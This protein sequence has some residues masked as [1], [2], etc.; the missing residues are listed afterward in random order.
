MTDEAVLFTGE[1]IDL[2]YYGVTG[3]SGP[4][5]TAVA[6]AQAKGVAGASLRRSRTPLTSEE[7][8]HVS[9]VFYDPGSGELPFFGIRP[10]FVARHSELDTLYRRMLRASDKLRVAIGAMEEEGLEE[11][12]SD[13]LATAQRLVFGAQSSDAYWRG[14]HPGFTDPRERDAVLERLCAAEAMIDTLIQGEQDWIG[15]EEEDR[16]GDL[17]EEV[18]AANRYLAAWL[19]PARAGA[20][21][22]LDDRQKRCSLL[23]AGVRRTEPF[24]ADMAQAELAGEAADLQGPPKRGVD[25]RRLAL[26]LPAVADDIERMGVREWLLDA[27]VT[28][29]EL[30]SGTV[31]RSA[32]ELPAT[33]VLENRIDE[34]GDCSYTLRVRSRLRL[35]GIRPRVATVYKATVLAIDAPK[36]SMAFDVELEGDGDALLALEVPLRLGTTTPRLHVDGESIETNRTVYPEVS[37]LRVDGDGRPVLLRMNPPL[38]VWVLPVRTTLRDLDGYRAVDQGLVAV[39]VLPVENRASMRVVLQ[40]GDGS[41]L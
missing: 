13:V 23:D 25:L 16:D 34:T 40:V 22:T 4:A 19:V 29:D 27:D 37:E 32:Q 11:A 30:F 5:A 2:S 1:L 20:I 38:D 35:D 39:P 18:F 28:P 36:V 6:E 24:I 31:D 33:E 21:R 26:D 41:P 10:G 12:W 17:V 9:P 14:P 3:V 8:K 15:T 7:A